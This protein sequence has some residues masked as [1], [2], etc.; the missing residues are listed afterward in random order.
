MSSLPINIATFKDGKNDHLFTH[1][2]YIITLYFND[3]TH[4]TLEDTSCEKY[5]NLFTFDNN[6]NFYNISS[7]ELSVCV[8]SVKNV[9]LNIKHIFNINEDIHI[10]KD[11]SIYIEITKNK[12][13]YANCCVHITIDKSRLFFTP[14]RY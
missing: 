1:Y 11:N 14:P 9:I 7:Y 10:Y 2:S 5:I 6:I 4:I 13:N 3:N 8:L 12:D